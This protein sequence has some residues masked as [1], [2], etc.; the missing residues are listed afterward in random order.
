MNAEPPHLQVVAPLSTSRKH[1]KKEPQSF[2]H[3]G[4]FDHPDPQSRKRLQ[5]CFLVYQLK[6]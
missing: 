3:C 4:P 5:I 1:G 2:F 6:F